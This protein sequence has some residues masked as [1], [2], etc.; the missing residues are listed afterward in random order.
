MLCRT[1][2]VLS[3]ACIAASATAVIDRVAIIV[4]KRVVKRS[5]I[6]RDLRASQFLNGEPPNLS[7]AARKKVAD[8][9]ITQELI[10]QEIMAGGYIRPSDQDVS[11]FIQKLRRE[12]FGNSEAQM[13]A[14]LARHGLTADQLRQYLLWQLTALQ[15][16]DQRF[17]SGV[18]VT[19]E[20][21]R[22]YYDA[23][24]S[25]LKQL[26]PQNDSL[27]AV[28]PKIREIITGERVNQNFEEWLEQAKRRMRIDYRDPALREESPK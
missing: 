28:E 23:H 21:I 2:A 27:Q 10:R 7:A 18:L 8:R 20:D 26:N 17:R 15:F 6:E 24:R 16:I 12:R 19:E 22:A 11:A 5:D 13:N 14:A 25:E 9:L 3:L 4:G 1:L